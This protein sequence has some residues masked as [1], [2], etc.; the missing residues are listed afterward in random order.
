[1]NKE[2][3]NA[4]KIQDQ[5]FRKMAAEKKIQLTSQ[6]FELGKTLQALNDRKINRDENYLKNLKNLFKN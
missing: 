2:V 1:M 4:Q 3:R 6:F 5:I